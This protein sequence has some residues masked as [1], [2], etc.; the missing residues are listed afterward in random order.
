[1]R[2]QQMTAT[3]GL[4]AAMMVL[5]QTPATAATARE[6]LHGTYQRLAEAE[7]VTAT[8]ETVT[9]I[10]MYR[11]VVA[12]LEYL[13]RQ[14][15]GWQAAVISARLA[16]AR[17]RLAALESSGAD[18]G[19]DDSPRSASADDSLIESPSKLMDAELARRE[20]VAQVE[21]Q[22]QALRRE[23]SELHARLQLVER[24]RQKLGDRDAM[25]PAVRETMS[26]ILVAEAERLLASN[27]VEP[28]VA[29]L[30]TGLNMLPRDPDIG[31]ALGVA[32]C[33]EGRFEAAAR[34][35]RWVS[36]ARPTDA[37]AR[38]ALGAAWM[39]QGKI[40]AARTEIEAALQADPQSA[41]AHYNM[42]RL[43]LIPPDTNPVMARRHY[44]QSVALGGA[45]DSEIEQIIQREAI[46]RIGRER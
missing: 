23:N 42:A 9:V 13:Q 27:A 30:E 5:A 34:I 38:L 44:M 26:R 1:M 41:D 4:A 10:R 6:R 16:L 31:L 22:N 18:G 14:Y 28:S 25:A 43:L 46:Q 24:Q 32:Y 3:A 21:I 17:N 7:G 39:G 19:R 40:G 45:P 20:A 8:G 29:L 37:M 12:D 2:W 33:R 15:P 11:D 35:L 36:V